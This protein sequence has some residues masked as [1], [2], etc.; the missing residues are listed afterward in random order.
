MGP[1]RG[2]FDFTDARNPVRDW[3]QIYVPYCTGD[4]H[5]GSKKNGSVPGLSN[6]QF[7]GYQNMKLFISRIVPTFKNRVTQVLLTGASAGG[8]GAAL[9]LSMVQDAFGDVPV[10][11]LSD[12]GPPLDDRYMP[13]C[14][15]K[16]WRDAWGFDESLPP[17]C[18]TC[19]Q[20]DGGGLL[21]LADFL[22]RKHPKT[23]L[24]IIST[25]Q[26]EVI[27]LVYSLGANNCAQSDTADP[28]TLSVAQ[29]IDPSLL[30]PADDF[31]AGLRALRDKYGPSERLATFYLAGA[32]PNF[33]QHLFRPD[34]Y[35]MFNGTTQAQFVSDFLTGKVLTVGP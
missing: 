32:N 8:F 34:F 13:V 33:H 26:D 6:Q 3:S 19:K 17:D 27:R 15:Q 20:A 30:M 4:V 35:E 22:L 21:N 10:D 18:D 31:T 5:F 11:A 23:R 24:G 12:S 25:V 7:M 28:I 9:N 1:P 14:M 16:R 2:I 29:L